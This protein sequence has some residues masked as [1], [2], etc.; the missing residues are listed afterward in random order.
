[1]SSSTADDVLAV[2]APVAGRALPLAEVPD[3]VFAE[4]MVGP[5]AAIDPP[6]AAATAVAPVAGRVAT[7]H[8]HAFVVVGPGSRGVLVHL[9]LDTVQLAGQG[10]AVLVSPGDEVSAGQ[11]MIRWDPGAVEAGGRSPVCPVIALDSTPDRLA[12]VRTAGEVRA[13]EVLF[14]W[15]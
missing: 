14:R 13:G 4:A 9:G 6:R 1:V 10:F 11:P 12:A 3:P 7:L 5:G 2:L 15:T 8:P